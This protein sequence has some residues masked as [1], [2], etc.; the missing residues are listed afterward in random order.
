MLLKTRA[1][2]ALAGLI[3]LVGVNGTALA[4]E[5]AY[6]EGA[7]VQVGSIR[8][9]PGMFDEYLKYL[10]GPYKQWMEEQKKAGIILDYAVY[11]TVPRGPHDPDLYLTV[12][13]KNMA[14]LDGLDA[15]TDPIAERIFGSME[16]SNSASA[17]R[18]K[19][20]TLV[21]SELI[22]ELVLK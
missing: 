11:Q 10:A 15:R 17:A 8:T 2:G 9:E 21:G 5:R 20:R 18:G 7:V 4:A 1:L 3:V 22:R 6:T 19:M 16:Q 13:Y 14:A 12:V